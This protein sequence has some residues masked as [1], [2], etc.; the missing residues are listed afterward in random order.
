M[1]VSHFTLLYGVVD[2]SPSVPRLS[3]PSAGNIPVP[4]FADQSAGQEKAAE[5]RTEFASQMK[6][7][8]VL[9]DVEVASGEKIVEYEKCI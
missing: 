2:P 4:V 6:Y 8:L 7:V 1:T 9:L 3:V 5:D